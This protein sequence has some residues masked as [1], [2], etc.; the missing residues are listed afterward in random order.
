MSYS[1]SSK[2][3]TRTTVGTPASDPASSSDSLKNSTNDFNDLSSDEEEIYENHDHRPDLPHCKCRQPAHGEMI[4]C[5]N[6]KCPVEWY[7]LDCVKL[8]EA[9]SG[10]WYCKICKTG[11]LKTIIPATEFFRWYGDPKK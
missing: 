8:K 4:A 6:P 9:P 7:H 5:D 2:T 1:P 10:K 3:D 11:K